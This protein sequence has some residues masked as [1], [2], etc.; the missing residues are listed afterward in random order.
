MYLHRNVSFFLKFTLAQIV[1]LCRV[2]ETTVIQGHNILFLQRQIGQAF[3]VVLGGE[4]EVWVDTDSTASR[5]PLS[6][7]QL[8]IMAN[9][10]KNYL[11]LVSDLGEKVSTLH[12]GEVFGERALDPASSNSQR[13]ASIVTCNEFTELLIIHKEDYLSLVYTI[14]NTDS[15]DRLSLLRRTEMFRA[16]DV[17]HLKALARFMEPRRYKIDD[18]IYS[19]GD[20]A[21][22]M[23]VIEVGECRVQIDVME[24]SDKKLRDRRRNS[25]SEVKTVNMGRIAPH[26]VLSAYITLCESS[27]HDILHTETIMATTIVECYVIS[28]HDFFLHVPKET[29]QVLKKVVSDFYSLPSYP[30]WE[31]IPRLLNR[32]QWAK[33]KC[34]ET[35]RKDLVA[36]EKK[37]SNILDHYKRLTNITFMVSVFPLQ[38]LVFGF[39]VKILFIF[40]PQIRIFVQRIWKTPHRRSRNSQKI[41]FPIL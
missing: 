5:P 25:K 27:Y 21:L 38:Y 26:S 12:V 4:V 37:D 2:A 34:W 31:N 16:V 3:Y 13:A 18:T 23:V 10:S 9:M 33:E 39:A 24:D 32:E 1:E 30:L 6:R 17:V 36:S 29:R 22:E 40:S 28:K 7:S 8:A 35:F 20:N 11:N 15:M 19:A 14:T 41:L